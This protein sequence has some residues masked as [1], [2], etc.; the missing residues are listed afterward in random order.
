M[1]ILSDNIDLYNYIKI[2]F[3]YLYNLC[4][5]NFMF[6]LKFDKKSYKYLLQTYNIIKFVFIDMM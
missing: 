5:K 4:K 3:M 2:K 1:I 6:F